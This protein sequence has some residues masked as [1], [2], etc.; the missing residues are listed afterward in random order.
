MKNFV[1]PTPRFIETSVSRLID[2]HCET[3]LGQMVSVW[4][5]SEWHAEISRV[6]DIDADRKVVDAVR[7]Q[8][9]ELV[10]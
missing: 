7:S 2:E 9:A 1:D 4:S 10:A 8:I 3:I 5:R 6:V